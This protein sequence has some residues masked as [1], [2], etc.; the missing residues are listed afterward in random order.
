MSSGRRK[1]D[2]VDPK[3]VPKAVVSRLSLYLRE[4]HHL[5]AGGHAT[6]SS[7]RLGQQLGFS[8]AQV[9][10]DL[11]YFGHFGQ[12]G[13]GYRCD[14]LIGAIRSIL[15]TDR[16]WR[17]AM[18]GVG[19]L[20]QALLGYRGFAS[21]G[22]TIVAAFD[23]DQTK[24]N[25]EVGGVPVYSLDDLAE[26]VRDKQIELGLVAVPANTAQQAADRLVAAGVA[27][28]L[29]FAPVTLNL[30]DH[31]SHVGVDLAT[32]LEQLCFSVANRSNQP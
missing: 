11:A 31:V 15:G 25:R 30:P 6:T 28:I 17:V 9:R 5:I 22:F 2:S 4:L 12:P 8:D 13:V 1:S 21:Q 3:D 24:T 14:E 7:G 32:E 16:E 27:G 10:R 20:G 26:V 19:N 23:V 18:I 29:N